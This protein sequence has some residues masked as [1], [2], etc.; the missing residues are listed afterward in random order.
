MNT[1]RQTTCNISPVE[2]FVLHADHK[3]LSRDYQQQ[4]SR[5]YDKLPILNHI[6][7]SGED[8]GRGNK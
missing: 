6:Y 8:G 5:K 4:R 3:C 2:H 7:N 1:L